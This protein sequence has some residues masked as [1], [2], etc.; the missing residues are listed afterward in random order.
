LR[1]SK[2]PGSREGAKFC[3]KVDQ[4]STDDDKKID[5]VTSGLS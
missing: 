4:H 5:R 2:R 3:S 1:N